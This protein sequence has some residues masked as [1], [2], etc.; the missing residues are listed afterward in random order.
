MGVGRPGP[1]CPMVPAG[2]GSVANWEANQ[3]DGGRGPTRTSIV[4]MQ[5]GRV[6]DTNL[7]IA[8]LCLVAMVGVAIFGSVWL[9]GRSQRTALE[10]AL[11]R[12]PAELVLSPDEFATNVDLSGDGQAACAGPIETLGIDVTD[13]SVR[14]RRDLPAIQST[15]HAAF[16][17]LD[18][19]DGGH[20]ALTVDE[21]VGDLPPSV[22]AID[23]ATGES[24][25]QHFVDA[26][27]IHPVLIGPDAIV[28]SAERSE[29]LNDGR[30]VHE[31]L[32]DFIAIDGSGSVRSH[33][34]MPSND[35]STLVPEIP[36]EY[37]H[38]SDQYPISPL[39]AD[40]PG[41][42][43][44]IRP[45][46]R[47]DFGHQSID[48]TDPVGGNT[49]TIDDLPFSNDFNVIG[50]DSSPGEPIQIG[51]KL[52]LVVMGSSFGPNTRLAVFDPTDGSPLWTLDHTRAAAVAGPNI[53]Y[54]KRNEEPPEAVSTR[55]IHLVSGRDPERELW[56]TALAVNDDGGNGFLGTSDGDLIFAVE[57]GDVG[58]EFL[59]I[60]GPDDVPDLIEAAAGYGSGPT[61]H[62]HVDGEVLA[63]ALPGG[64]VV[65][66]VERQPVLVE[67]DQPP[68]QVT[69]SGDV[70]LVV[71]NHNS[72]GCD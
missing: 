38:L 42:E 10:E 23:P 12:Q 68:T 67:T 50:S 66:P 22:V 56:S 26:D 16:A 49:M 4:P 25:W 64:V 36:T 11:D 43:P 3:A 39:L 7:V 1:R 27:N 35:G 32:V 62:H 18:D 21:W 6:S 28:L 70:L 44:M 47:D 24:R 71:A 29:R 48:V 37:A 15:H 53:L 57:G 19:G 58:L 31:R 65:Q 72:G 54:D 52:M 40:W 8:M 61:G 55:D 69:R 30:E 5:T 59:S 34:S 33:P 60:G 17:V 9:A 13:G 20:V 2:V 46:E 14:W 51:S 63:A 45:L 41:V